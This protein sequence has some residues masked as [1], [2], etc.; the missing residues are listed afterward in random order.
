VRGLFA[1]GDRMGQLIGHDGKKR[2]VTF[3]DE[4][5]GPTEGAYRTARLWSRLGMIWFGIPAAILTVISALLMVDFATDLATTWD[6]VAKFSAIAIALSLC[7]TGLLAWAGLIEASHPVEAQRMQAAWAGLLGLA[8]VAMLFFVFRLDA[9]TAS[10]SASSERAA[11]LRASFATLAS[12]AEWD[13]WNASNGCVAPPAAFRA[14]CTAITLRRDRE[15]AELQAIEAGS[16]VSGWSPSALIGTG[17][18]AGTFEDGHWWLAA[19]LPLTTSP[20]AVRPAP[21]A[22]I[23]ADDFTLLWRLAEPVTTERANALVAR[24]VGSAGKPANGE[25]VPL[26]GTILAKTVG[27]GLVERFPV[28]VL[29]PPP[30]PGYRIVGDGLVDVRH[31][32]AEPL[33]PRMMAVTLADDAVWQPGAQANAF[34]LI[35]GGSGAGKTEAIKTTGA[36][37][38]R[39]GIPTLTFDFHGDVVVPGSETILLASGSESTLG[40]NP[41]ELYDASAGRQGLYDQRRAFCALVKRACPALGH[42]QANLPKVALEAIYRNAGILDAEPFNLGPHAA[43]D[44]RPDARTGAHRR[45]RS[46]QG[47]CRRG[48]ERGRGRSV[49]PPHLPPQPVHQPQRSPQGR[50][51]PRPL[52]PGGRREDGGDRDAAAPHLRRVAG[53]GHIPVKP[54]D[55]TE[56]FRL[57]I[58]IDEVQKLVAG[59]GAEILDILFREARKFGLGMILGTQSAS[60]LTKDIRAN[61]SCWL[62]LLHNEIEEARRTAPNIGVDPEDLMNLRGRGDGYLKQRSTATRRIQVRQ[63]A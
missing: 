50:R 47:Q 48:P 38:A 9:P 41:L 56:R 30:S 61:A 39:Y 5:D 32:P 15:W 8:A 49:R 26:P 25:P 36:G 1:T 2:T 40:V 14:A 46:D 13:A 18:V 54:V 23:A 4:G 57:F 33:D 11:A 24:M 16:W 51:P 21:Q 29:P 58:I 10:P 35:V 60:N 55:D 6:Q 44:G 53:P 12:P 28:R 31:K 19:R 37:A 34:F 63:V 52:R 27:A 43:A 59:G 62:A 7:S 45:G 20:S 42:K 17:H 22:I 3:G